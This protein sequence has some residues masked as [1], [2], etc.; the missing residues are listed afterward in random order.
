LFPASVSASSK[1]AWSPSESPSIGEEIARDDPPA[2]SIAP[3][4]RDRAPAYALGAV[5]APTAEASPGKFAALSG[6][7]SPESVPDRAARLAPAREIGS[8]NGPGL[9]VAA[10]DAPVANAGD[11]A[12]IASGAAASPALAHRKASTAPAKGLWRA[13]FAGKSSHP[14]RPLGY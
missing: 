13:A 10:L 14:R 6:T 12:T 1:A 8:D 9:T 3:L 2:R 5:H 4:I 11:R 7:F